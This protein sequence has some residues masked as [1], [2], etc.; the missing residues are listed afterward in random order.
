MLTRAAHV[1]PAR[2]QLLLHVW[3][4]GDAGQEGAP[5]F[6]ACCSVSAAALNRRAPIRSDQGG[7]RLRGRRG[8]RAVPGSGD[9]QRRGA[10]ALG[11]CR[12]EAAALV[13]S[14]VRGTTAL[15]DCFA[16][17]AGAAPDPGQDA[18]AAQ[19]RRR[20]SDH[21]VAA[22]GGRCLPLR[23][24]HS[25]GPPTCC[26]HARAAGAPAPRGAPRAPKGRR[27]ASLTRPPR[28]AVAQLR[29]DVGANEGVLRQVRTFRGSHASA[30]CSIDRPP[31]HQLRPTTSRAGL[32]RASV[33]V[34]GR[35]A[36]ASCGRRARWWAS[37]R[38]CLCRRQSRA[39]ARR[40]RC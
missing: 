19:R 9:A 4:R 18:R 39:A 10:R 16:F 38:G 31:S 6:R 37:R 1:P 28:R 40:R 36:R 24:G 12:R 21:R 35:A 22:A 2:A 3:P 33:R 34:S 13:L 8:R 5:L 26:A 30:A 20:A 25:V 15:A 17:S 29:H 11:W 32:T 7:R 27:S 23:H 14:N